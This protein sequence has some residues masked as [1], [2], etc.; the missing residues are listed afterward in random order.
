MRH[1]VEHFDSISDLVRANGTRGESPAFRG[2]SKYSD[3]PHEWNPGWAGTKSYSEASELLRSGWS[4]P[5]A[6]IKAAVIESD[7]LDTAESL[8]QM[9]MIHDVRGSSV[10]VP[11][12][13]TGHPQS[14]RRIHVEPLKQK[15]VL[16]GYCISANGNVDGDTLTK[17]GIAVLAAVNHLE[18]RGVRVRLDVFDQSWARSGSGDNFG[19]SLTVK[20]Y[21]EPLN[22]LKLAFPICHPSMLRRIAFRWVETAPIV[23]DTS[24]V[25]GYGTAISSANESDRKA[26]YNLLLPNGYVFDPADVQSAG[27][28]PDALLERAGVKID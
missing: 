1:F 25:G 24:L 2:A 17:C 12:Y 15:T 7:R 13:M 14:M 22:L 5:L 6:K 26:F 23:T 19:W 28:K 18:R 16:L 4:E 21:R 9:Q 27:Y 3:N 8:T 20:D 10:S 11:R